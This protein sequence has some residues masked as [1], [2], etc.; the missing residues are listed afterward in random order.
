MRRARDGH[1]V[2]HHVAKVG[3]ERRELVDHV[4]ET[5]EVQGPMSAS[6]FAGEKRSGSWSGWN[7]T[8]SAVE[9]LFWAGELAVHSRRTSFERVYDLAD[10]VIQQAFAGCPN[11]P[12]KKRSEGSWLSRRTLSA[13]R[14]GAIF[15]TIF[16][17][18]RPMQSNVSQ[19]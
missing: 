10:R 18:I 12:L 17:S 6:E 1:G 9:H 5:I 4:R 15:A 13:W 14:R 2:W 7:D 8:K 3:R 19:N 11:H 16:G